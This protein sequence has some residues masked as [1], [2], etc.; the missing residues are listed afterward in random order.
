MSLSKTSAVKWDLIIFPIR[1]YVCMC[2][3]IH[4]YIYIY[5]DGLAEDTGAL[6]RAEG[7]LGATTCAPRPVWLDVCQRWLVP[8]ICVHLFPNSK[9]LNSLNPKPQDACKPQAEAIKPR[10]GVV[11]DPQRKRVFAS[12]GCAL[13][14]GFASGFRVEGHEGFAAS[15]QFQQAL[16]C[17]YR[18][19][20]KTSFCL[21]KIPDHLVLRS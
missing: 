18:S 21:W 14:L 5:L 17:R 3:Y 2:I 6:A 7:V 9:F 20:C 12:Q 15:R 8:S 10:T 11:A 16:A 19:Y 1:R 4:I 13:A